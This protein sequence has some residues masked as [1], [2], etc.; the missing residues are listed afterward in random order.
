MSSAYDL[1]G[2]SA[3]GLGRSSRRSTT[4]LTKAVDME[5]IG[6][7]ISRL[8]ANQMSAGG[9]ASKRSSTAKLR[10]TV[11]ASN[12]NY[13][14]VMEIVDIINRD[15]CEDVFNP[16]IRKLNRQIGQRSRFVYRDGKIVEDTEAGRQTAE[17]VESE[18]DYLSNNGPQKVMTSTST[19]IIS[20]DSSILNK[21]TRLSNVADKLNELTDF[22]KNKKSRQLSQK[23]ERLEVIIERASQQV[24]RESFSK[25]V[26]EL[27]DQRLDQVSRKVVK[28]NYAT[29]L[30]FMKMNLGDAIEKTDELIIKYARQASFYEIKSLFYEDRMTE[31]KSS[32]MKKSCFE[33]LRIN[34]ETARLEK[35]QEKTTQFMIKLDTYLLLL[36]F[37]AFF[38]IRLTDC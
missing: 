38:N 6:L 31:I 16:L 21:Q 19:G 26:R 35:I 14:D 17:I 8:S 4:T 1:L 32:I 25:L 29:M 37:N 18:W 12:K 36:K 2:N 28:A 10:S 23:L 33:T 27:S 3:G 7:Q 13:D 5:G 34:A 11:H 24:Y 15:P 30:K 9:L 20:P 22:V